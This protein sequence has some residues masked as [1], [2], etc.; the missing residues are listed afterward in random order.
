MEKIELSREVE[1]FLNLIKKI[2]LEKKLSH[3]K[4]ADKAG[5]SRS[6][7]GLLESHRRNPTILVSF[8]IAKALGVKLK[9]M[10]AKVER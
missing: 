3:Q 6:M 1:A 5:L 9:D 4:L 8:K 10:I 7:I 2:R